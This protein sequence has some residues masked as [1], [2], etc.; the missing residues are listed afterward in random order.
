MVAKI[1]IG[2]SIRG[3]LHYNENKVATGEARLIMAS[4]LQGTSTI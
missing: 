4:G 3:I 1:V 2:K